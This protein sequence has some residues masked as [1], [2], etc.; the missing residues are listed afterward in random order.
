MG[1]ADLQQ[2][3]QVVV[4]GLGTGLI[5]GLIGVGFAIIFNVTALINLA[6]GEFSMLGA[7]MAT[8]LLKQVGLGLPLAFAVSVVA[9]TVVGVVFERLC[10]S[11]QRGASVQAAII[12]TL[13]AAMFLRGGAM[14]AWGKD[15][16]SL[17]AFSGHG[18][19]TVVGVA[20][21]LQTLWVFG[22]GGVLVG[23]LWWFFNRTLF[24][25][26]MRACAQN[27]AGAAFVGIDV[28]LMVTLSFAISA[29]LGAI[30]GIVIAPLTFV[31]YDGGLILGLKGFVAAVLGGTG[32]YLGAM[33]GGL[34]LGA[35][36]SLSAGY[37][38]S[39]YK[40]A[41]A[42]GLLIVV[43]SLRPAGLLGTREDR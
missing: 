36:E 17:P 1:H 43:L 11:R 39:T 32:T 3:A 37:V 30:A 16:Y 12:I 8:W 13:G 20:V 28:R 31:S 40:D 26:A 42:F 38:S 5:Y 21:P 29:A 18:A 19:L 10:I 27:R 35:L 41:V 15:P 34:L 14:V 6:Q 33:A 2:L 9:V 24:G 22:I 4:A 7:V 23:L 25:W